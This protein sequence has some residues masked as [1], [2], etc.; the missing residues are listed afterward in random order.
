MFHSFNKV[1][2]GRGKFRKKTCSEAS[3]AGFAVQSFCTS[4][5][6]MTNFEF[7]FAF[8]Y[9]ND[10]QK[11]TLTDYQWSQR[12]GERSNIHKDKQK[13]YSLINGC[14]VFLPAGQKYISYCTFFHFLIC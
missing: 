12:W 3:D 11:K 1:L 6:A 7:G 5:D 14:C 2:P 4:P 13:V 8:R 9:R 10:V